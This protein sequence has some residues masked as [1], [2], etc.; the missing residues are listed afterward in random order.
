MREKHQR[1]VYDVL[2][3]R[4][5]IVFAQTAITGHVDAQNEHVSFSLHAALNHCLNH[6]CCRSHFAERLHAVQHIFG[7]SRFARRNLQLRLAGNTVDRC[8]QS[9]KNRC[10]GSVHPDKN[11]DAQHN[12]YCREQRA[13]AVF[14]DVLPTDES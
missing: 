8:A 10:S 7:K 3:T 1:V 12:S 11:R 13:Q 2:V 6:G 5:Q 14:A 4:L 9:S